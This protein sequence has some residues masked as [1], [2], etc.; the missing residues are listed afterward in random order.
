MMTHQTPY[1]RRQVRKLLLYICGTKEKYR[2]LRDLQA[3]DSHMK[4]IKAIVGG[5]SASLDD[6]KSAMSNLSYD[7]LLQLI[8][9]LKACV[10]V[11]TSRLVG[12]ETL[13]SLIQTAGVVVCIQASLDSESPMGGISVS[14]QFGY[15]NPC[16]LW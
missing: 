6:R 4:K 10:D 16:V 8:E 11:A 9:H 3:L 14:E 12:Y 1:V 13:E 5:E 15:R 7:T 2:E